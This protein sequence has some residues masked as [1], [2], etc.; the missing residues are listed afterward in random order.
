MHLNLG[1]PANAIYDLTTNTLTHIGYL[2]GYGQN[3]TLKINSADASGI[4]NFYSNGA[5]DQLV[6]SDAMLDLSH[7]SVSGFTVASTNASGTT[8][9]VQDVGTAFQIAGGPGQDTIVANGFAFTADQ[10]NAIFTTASV[11]KIIER[12]ARIRHCPTPRTREP[13][14]VHADD[15]SRTPCGWPG[16]RHGE[17]DGGDVKGG[18]YTG[19]SG[20][21]VLALY[22]SGEFHIEEL[23]I[24]TG[25]ESIALNNFT[26]GYAVLC[27]VAKRLQ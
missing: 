12:A 7:S 14:R 2:Y 17:R 15:R 23:A 3:L 26:S 4:A 11:E 19:G 13:E 20:N 1:G 16:R 24:F 21:D 10:R 22:G 8:F 9:T 6:T 18:S 5:S 25:F 27:L